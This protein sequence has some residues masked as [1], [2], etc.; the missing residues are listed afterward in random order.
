MAHR[1]DFAQFD[2]IVMQVGSPSVPPQVLVAWTI[3]P[4]RTGATDV[5]F[6]VE[7]S[8]SPDFAD[9]DAIEE[10]TTALPG[11]AGQTVYEYLDITVNLQ[12]FWRRWYYRIRAEDTSLSKEYTSD[13]K[14]WESDAKIFELEIIARHDWLLRYETGTPCFALIE[15]TA[16]GDHCQVCYN[17]SLGRPSKSQCSE[18]FGTGRERPFFQPILT[19]VDFNPPAKATQ[20]SQRE[21]QVGQTNVW[22]S[23][24]PQLKPRDLLVEVLSGERWRVVSVNP[25]GDVR[26]SVQ[27]FATLERVSQRDIE[28]QIA[29]PVATQRSAVNELDAMK[30]E[31]RF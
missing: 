31:R 22:W 15:R 21:M 18:C 28:H 20:M 14:T 12:N 7:R 16:G 24:F 19:F 10:I 17:P 23:A 11:V 25:V 9:E 5:L 8:Q 26:T 6:H 3:E 4:I 2:I 27:H 29:I 30:A 1:I 13:V